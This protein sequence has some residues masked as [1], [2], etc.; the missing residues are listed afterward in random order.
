MK[1]LAKKF[2]ENTHS[3]GHLKQQQKTSEYFVRI[4]SC[5]I[6]RAILL[7]HTEFFSHQIEREKNMIQAAPKERKEY[8]S[9]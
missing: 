7:I 9:S 6:E 2:I 3:F 4:Q 1:I 8:D 5:H